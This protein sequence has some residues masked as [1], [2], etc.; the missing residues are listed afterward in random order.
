MPTQLLEPTFGED[1]STDIII[2]EGST[3][4]VAIF[5]GSSMDNLKLPNGVDDFLI[6]PATDPS[7]DS[8]LLP[9]GDDFLLPDGFSQLLINTSLSGDL[10]LFPT[11]NQSSKIMNKNDYALIQLK[12][13][14][15]GYANSG[16]SLRHNGLFKTLGPGVWRLWKPATPREFGFQSE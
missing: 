12:D 2:A 16:L 10:L 3:N 9:S 6:A 8:F 1:V 13:P 15:G 14:A 11:A 5:Q 7:G 4:T